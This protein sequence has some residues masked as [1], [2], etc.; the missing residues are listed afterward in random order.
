[1]LRYCCLRRACGDAGRMVRARPALPKLAKLPPTEADLQELLYR[2]ELAVHKGEP[3]A[4]AT[5]R[6]LWQ[7]MQFSFVFEVAL[8][9]NH[10]N[11][12]IWDKQQT[13]P[14]S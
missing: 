14:P 6:K 10:S 11:L 5:L 9:L 4:F 1:M 12:D 8:L 7:A 2:F 13:N 3:C